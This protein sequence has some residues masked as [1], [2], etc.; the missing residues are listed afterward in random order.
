[1]D[2]VKEAF[3]RVRQDIDFLFSEVVSIKEE[4]SQTRDLMIELGEFIKSV[5]KNTQKNLSNSIEYPKYK[6]DFLQDRQINQQTDRHINKTNSTHLS[7]QNKDFKALND[8]NLRVS[9]GNG[10]V[11]TDRQTNQQTNQQTHNSSYNQDYN[12]TKPNITNYP[13][14]VNTIE[15][16]LNV[17]DSLDNIKKEIR[18]KFK[19]LTDQEMSVFTLLYQ[20]SEEYGFSDYKTLSIKLNLTES[21]IRDYVGRLIK[22]GI[23]VEKNKIN[24]KNIQLSISPDLKKIANLNT[25]LKLRE[26]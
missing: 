22:K 21:S 16:A 20:L 19:R 7:T 25:I 8:Q 23:P 13:K 11:P 17:L 24:N 10:G 1:M 14:E 5:Q 3:S 2:E 26:I 6:E 15:N 12:H 18:L 4:L 9:N